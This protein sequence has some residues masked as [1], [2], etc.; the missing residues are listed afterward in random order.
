M[1]YIIFLLLLPC[2]S[3]AQTLIGLYGDVG[4][5]RYVRQYSRESISPGTAWSGG[6]TFHFGTSKRFNALVDLGY[7]EKK[8]S[9]HYHKP[10]IQ[11]PFLSAFYKYKEL[12]LNLG[13]R[14]NILN[15]KHKPFIDLAMN[16]NH[17]LERSDKS[18]DDNG[19]SG[20]IYLPIDNRYYAGVLCGVGYNYN[21][22]FSVSFIF[23]YALSSFENYY[24]NTRLHMNA[25]SL[26]YF[27]PV[28]GAKI[29]KKV[30]AESNPIAPAP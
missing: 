21:N 10:G 4:Q 6:A 12:H 22:K 9:L 23:K 14:F 3:Q 15:K 19:V 8:Y 29:P 7:S 16:N 27:I 20:T 25:V 26:C 2:A 18:K 5:S 24:G 17:I 30:S 1:R 13:V 28:L 11:D